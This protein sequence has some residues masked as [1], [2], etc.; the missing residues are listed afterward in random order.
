MFDK[1]EFT[2]TEKFLRYVE[3]DTQSDA[4][5]PTVPSTEKQ[6]NL[7]HLLAT[8]LQKMGIADA[9]MDNMGYVYAT[10]P[11]NSEKQVDAVCFCAHVDTS[12]DCSGENVKPI[13]HKAYNGGDIILPDDTTQ[14]LNPKNHPEL[15]SKV[16]FWEFARERCP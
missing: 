16:F 3:I 8:E 13:I 10:I 7:S 11:S 2:V 5:S 15:A 9:E 14:I 4:T 1:Y 12:P 6:K